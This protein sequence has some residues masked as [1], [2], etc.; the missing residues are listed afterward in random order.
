MDN[1]IDKRQ[2]YN[3]YSATIC[4]GSV[5]IFLPDNV[6]TLRSCNPIK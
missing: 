3:T 6:R 1:G 5:A 4:V 2:N